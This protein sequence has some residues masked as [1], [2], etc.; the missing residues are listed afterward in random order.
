M[1]YKRS[2][3]GVGSKVRFAQK[4]SNESSTKYDYLIGQ[5][6]RA[7]D[8]EPH[9]FPVTATSEPIGNGMRETTIVIKLI[10][11]DEYHVKLDQE[12]H[13]RCGFAVFS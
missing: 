6:N 1:A 10:E 3:S 4:I 2:T 11:R 13:S 9:E 12:L 7:Y 8:G 5:I